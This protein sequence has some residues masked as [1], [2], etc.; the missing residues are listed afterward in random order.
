M[1]KEENRQMLKAFTLAGTIGLNMAATIAVGLFGGKWLDE[2]FNTAP[3]ATVSGI[4]LGMLAGLWS[5]YKR[6]MDKS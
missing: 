2:Y 3:F 4:V 5:A 1:S 6:I